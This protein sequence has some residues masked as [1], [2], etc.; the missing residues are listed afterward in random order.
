MTD[1]PLAPA[2]EPRSTRRA[3][4]RAFWALCQRDG[5]VMVSHDLGGFLAQSLL[6]PVFFL[7]VFG[8]ILPEIGAAQG[9]YGAQLL[10]GVVAL[11]LV[12]TSLQNV[13]LP[14]VIEFAFTKEIEDRLLAP[15]P[16]WLVG[17]QKVAFGSFR[18]V[19]AAGL[20]LPLAAVIL[21]GGIDLGQTSWPALLLV[22]AAGSVAGAAV[23]LVMGT[24]VPVQKINVVFAVVLT[25]LIFTG[26]TFYPWRG[27]DG[28]RW[29]QLL[30]LANPL[31]YVSEGMRGA[32]SGLPHMGT[33][34]LVLGLGV[35]L[36][37]GIAQG[38]R[39]FVG[40]AVD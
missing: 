31:T 7:L 4:T 16:A 24:A 10:P 15:L 33:G 40:R 36:T 11:T 27:L 19:I 8:R 28:L 9:S 25:P 21:P 3:S 12:L 2:L 20:V 39:G 29:F 37:V 18:G 34:Y 14:L 17:V 6:Q 13:A 22:F 30:T 38:V 5:W 23:G 1:S 35:A 26:A 32:L